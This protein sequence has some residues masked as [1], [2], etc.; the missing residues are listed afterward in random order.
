MEEKEK[1]QMYIYHL[2]KGKIVMDRADHTDH[3]E[4]HYAGDPDFKAAYVA[5]ADKPLTEAEIKRFADYY[6][7]QHDT[8]VRPAL[9]PFT[10]SA[11]KTRKTFSTRIPAGRK[12]AA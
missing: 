12:V 8:A 4:Q 11:P 7:A 5:G 6:S 9:K 3:L 10:A 1:K 2:Y